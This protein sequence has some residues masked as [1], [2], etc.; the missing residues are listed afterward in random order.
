MNTTNQNELIK[1]KQVLELIR[2]GDTTS[3]AIGKVFG[4]P[5]DKWAA[6]KAAYAQGKRIECRYRSVQEKPWETTLIPSWLDEFEY[7]I[8]PYPA[9]TYHTHTVVQ[10]RREEAAAINAAMNPAPAGK[11]TDE[12]LAEIYQNTT[13]ASHVGQSVYKWDELTQDHRDARIQGIRAVREAVEKEQAEEIAQLTAIIEQ[14]IE[15]VNTPGTT[16]GNLPKAINA[17]IMQRDEF[18]DATLKKL[19]VAKA[20]ISR[21]KTEYESLLKVYKNAD[22]G[23]RNMHSE[24]KRLNASLLFFRAVLSASTLAAT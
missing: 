13:A 6:E 20:E 16:K 7:R 17:K 4:E 23:A 2:A 3:V 11:L 22:E 18:H 19:D 24:L 9:Q 10:Q 15:M 8:A 5:A 1:T 21:L 12:Q 14:S